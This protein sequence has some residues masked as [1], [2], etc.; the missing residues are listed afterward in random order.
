MVDDQNIWDSNNLL[1][2]MGLGQLRLNSVGSRYPLEREIYSTMYPNE[3][4]Y[5]YGDFTIVVPM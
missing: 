5:G 1:F 4:T 2:V 3:L